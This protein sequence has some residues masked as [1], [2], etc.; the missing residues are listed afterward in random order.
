MNNQFNLNNKVFELSSLV[1]VAGS[2]LFEIGAKLETE[3]HKTGTVNFQ[4][5]IKDLQVWGTDLI[6]KI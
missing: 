5:A 2:E 6:I 1:N 3:R 4:D